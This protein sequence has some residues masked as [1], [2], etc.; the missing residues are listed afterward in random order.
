MSDA[1]LSMDE[2]SNIG[3]LVVNTYDDELNRRYMVMT[4]SNTI[5]HAIR[6]YL[7]T[8]IMTKRLYSLFVLSVL[9]EIESEIFTNKDIRDFILNVTDRISIM[10]SVT[11]VDIDRLIESIVEGMARNR[12]ADIDN[13]HSIVN[14]KVQAQIKIEPAALRDLL[15]DNFWLVCLVVYYLFGST[16]KSIVSDT[17]TI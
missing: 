12:P 17:V 13:S 3:S 11:D 2:L 10:L 14:H 5:G 9:K 7:N 4:E 8:F 1:K 15:K 6:I 16:S